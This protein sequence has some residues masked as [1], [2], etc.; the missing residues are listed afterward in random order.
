MSGGVDLEARATAR[1][2]SAGR[3][4]RSVRC[5]VRRWCRIPAGEPACLYVAIIRT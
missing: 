5:V 2:R 1:R 4:A 3:D